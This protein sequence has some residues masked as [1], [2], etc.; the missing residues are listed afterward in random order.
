[1]APDIRDIEEFTQNAWPCLRQV[2]LDGWIVR[3]AGGYTRRSNSVN[4][5]YPGKL[6]PLD[7]V[8]TCE[9]MFGRAG[10]APV[11]KL[12]PASFPHGLDRVLLDAGYRKEPG[13]SV[14]LVDLHGLD[15]EGRADVQTWDGPSDEWI[16]AYGSFTARD[17]D[18]RATL[19]ALLNN[20]VP[21][22]LFV[23]VP[24]DG[25]IAS[26]AMAV[27]QP[28]WV[29]LFNMATDPSLRRRGFG[30]HVVAAVLQWGRER[31]ATTGCLQV[32]PDNA[33]AIGLYS[34]FAFSEAYQY[35]Y[36]VKA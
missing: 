23:A 28:P 30:R 33:P 5:L 10:L 1:L 11:F 14:R 18:R 7:K 24:Q 34:Q 2:L 17:P 26:V 25:R 36:F 13:A 3:F 22:T 21:Q 19:Q 35:H 6:D 29:G 12:T 31:G 32:S 15:V 27:A 9:G 8:R 20:I 16:E 4:P